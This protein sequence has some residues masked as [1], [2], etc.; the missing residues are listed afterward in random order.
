MN[1]RTAG[2]GMTSN[3]TR[4]RMVERLRDQG[5]KDEL[6]LASMSEIPRHVFVDEA[7]AHRAYEDLSLPIG[8]GQTISNPQT[9]ARMLE[10]LRGGR[11]LKRVLEIGSG[12]GYQAALLSRLAKHVWT[13]ERLLPLVSKTRINLRDLNIRNVKAKH[14]DGHLGLPEEAPFDGIVMAAAASHVPEQLLD[15]LA[16]GGRLIM[17]LGP[18]EQ[19]LTL[20]E[21]DDRGFHRSVLE[22]VH[23]VPLVPGVGR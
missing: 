13:I 20:I 2:V 4:M 14:G 6:V 12:C 23:F 5:I 9:V 1:T 21:R 22:A 3:R 11:M 16:L 19:Q 7:L 17:P 8:Y 10:I 15:Q 18:R